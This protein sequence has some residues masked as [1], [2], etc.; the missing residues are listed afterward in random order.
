MKK[1]WGASTSTGNRHWELVIGAGIGTGSSIV[2]LVLVLRCFG[3]RRVGRGGSTVQR[4]S[5]HEKEN[6]SGKTAEWHF[7]VVLYCTPIVGRS[8]LESQ[9]SHRSGRLYRAYYCSSDILSRVCDLRR[10]SEFICTS[11]FSSVDGGEVVV[12]G[13]LFMRKLA[14]HFRVE[15][16]SG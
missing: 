1:R 15:R 6:G 11:T 12:A 10:S 16:N 9:R 14:G 7:C 3:R 8:V 5:L 13:R 4:K 2:V